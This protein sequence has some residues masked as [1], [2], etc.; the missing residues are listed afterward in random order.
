[1]TSRSIPSL[2][3]VVALGGVARAD[4]SLAT[5]GRFQIGAR[6][7]YELVVGD[8]SDPYDSGINPFG[9][10]FGLGVG[11]TLASGL[12]LGATFDA[13]LGESDTEVDEES[14]TQA[15]YDVSAWNL[16]ARAGW[17]IGLTPAL[18]LRPALGLGITHIAA[19]V[20]IAGMSDSESADH[21]SLRPEVGALYTFG[22]AF[23]SLE[24]GF[25]IDTKVTK[26]SGASFVLGVGGAF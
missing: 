1:M 17:D 23:V 24:I 2:L 22:P 20:T 3:A 4:D 13:H 16:L 25:L 8:D 11:Y 21:F 15:S 10:G 26:N 5:A 7:G 19:E 14:E 6:I 12:H 18:V 9:L